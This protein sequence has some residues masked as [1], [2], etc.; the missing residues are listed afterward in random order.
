MR[1]LLGTA[2][3]MWSMVLWSTGLE[4]CWLKHVDTYLLVGR[5][6]LCGRACAGYGRAS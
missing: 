6:W 5:R 4:G 3:R 1:K 2:R